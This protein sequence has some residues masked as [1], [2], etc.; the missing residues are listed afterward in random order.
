MSV[1][2]EYLRICHGDLAL[3]E[4][5]NGEAPVQVFDSPGTAAPTVDADGESGKSNTGDQG[6]DGQADEHLE[7]REST[8]TVDRSF[9]WCSADHSFE[10]LPPSAIRHQCC[11]RSI[12]LARLQPR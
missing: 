3:K 2:V 8:V 7:Q 10:F 12:G 9:E 6:H 1:T 4:A 5:F 11:V